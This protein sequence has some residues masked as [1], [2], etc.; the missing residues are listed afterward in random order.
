M[1]AEH[2]SLRALAALGT[3]LALACALGGCGRDA[4]E[5]ETGANRQAADGSLPRPQQP[6]GSVTG[7]SGVQGPGDVPLGGAQ[8]EAQAAPEDPLLPLEDNPETGLATASVDEALAAPEPSPDEAAAVIRTYYAAINALDYGRAYA[9][10]S[11]GGRASGQSPDGFAAGFDGTSVVMVDIGTPGA[12]ESA[13]GSRFIRVP[14]SL[15]AQ[16]TDGSSR[17]FEGE[18]VLRRAAV[19]GASDAQRTWRI[20]SADLREVSTP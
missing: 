7:L 4:A 9:L 15:R 10:W 20:A 13:A 5:H 17:R 2:R 1:S 12:I 18:Y 11:D 3:A 6:A 19:D 8:P 14:V 16:Q